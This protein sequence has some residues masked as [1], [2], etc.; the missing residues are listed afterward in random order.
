V[1]PTPGL[2]PNL[3]VDEDE[4]ELDLLALALEVDLALREPDVGCP[5]KLVLIRNNRKWNRN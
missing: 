4:E 3:N 1:V 5:S 2:D